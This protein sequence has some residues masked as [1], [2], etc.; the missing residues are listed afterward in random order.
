MTITKQCC[1]VVKSAQQHSAY[2][3][4]NVY[5]VSIYMLLIK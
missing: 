1:V 5:I 4:C 3:P 2:K